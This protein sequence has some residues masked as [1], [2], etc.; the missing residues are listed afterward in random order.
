MTIHTLWRWIFSRRMSAAEVERRLDLP[1]R[2]RRL[3]DMIAM[4]R[5]DALVVSAMISFM[6]K[7]DSEA[8][9]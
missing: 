1:R 3:D 2:W 8:M 5:S 6:Q 4:S 9:G 7:R